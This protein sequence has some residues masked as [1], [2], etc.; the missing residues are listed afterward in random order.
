MP[1]RSENVHAGI[2]LILLSDSRRMHAAGIRGC[3]MDDTDYL[4]KRAAQELQAAAV[5]TDRRVIDRHFEMA[6]AYAF[7]LSVT[8]V[9][10]QGPVLEL[11]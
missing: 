1:L 5:A 2:S 11:L 6:D 9:M 8:R 3:R 10:Q 7:R 4:A